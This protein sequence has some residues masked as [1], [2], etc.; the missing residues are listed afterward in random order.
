MLG[1]GVGLTLQPELLSVVEAWREYVDYV[2]LVPDTAWTD[3]GREAV[4]RYIDD[5]SLRC[6]LES[7][8]LPVVLHGIGLSIGS[9]HGFDR[10]HLQQVHSWQRSLGARWHSDHLAWHLASSES[11]EINVNLTLPIALDH[12]S[13]GR[14]IER[15]NYIQSVIEVPFLLENNVYYFD[16]G[17]SDMDEATFLSSVATATGC[18]LLLDLHNLW[19]NVVNRGWNVDTYLD[20]LDLDRVIEIHVAGEAYL[21]GFVL[22]AHAGAVPEAVWDLMADT[23]PRCPD[24]QGVTFELFGTWFERLGEAGL[25][26]QLDRARRIV[27]VVAAST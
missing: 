5:A 2:E 13:L 23:A 19:V 24:L 1:R 21:D 15:V 11:G 22:D 17:R 16:G 7:Q 20:R 10:A 9:A 27:G 14:V 6:W 3:L 8:D 18:G 26:A 12:E 4:P 25:L